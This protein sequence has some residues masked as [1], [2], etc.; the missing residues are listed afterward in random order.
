MKLVWKF[1]ATRLGNYPNT[2]LVY[3]CVR[4]TLTLLNVFLGWFEL[5][6]MVVLSLFCFGWKFPMKKG[7]N[8]SILEA[9]PLFA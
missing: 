8:A 4:K 6:F 7:K 9:R 5:G 2:F 3:V 1:K